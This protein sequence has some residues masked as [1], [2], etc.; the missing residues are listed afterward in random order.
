[1]PI[2]SMSDLYYSYL[3]SIYDGKKQ[4]LSMLPDMTSIALA[5]E[6]ESRLHLCEQE[7]S[8]QL[9]R[10][11][12]IFAALKMPPKE[13][14]C[15]AMQAI[16]REAGTMIA[17]ADPNVRDACLIAGIQRAQHYAITS[18]GT[19]RSFAATL[20][21]DSQM[22]LLDDSLQEERLSDIELTALAKTGINQGMQRNIAA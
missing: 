11:K 16:L 14:R 18:Y 17:N 22:V 8:R 12:H 15:E 2:N 6:L 3:S 19:L 1:M 7:T 4:M 20:G 5:D 10:L 9:D 13:V 21:Y